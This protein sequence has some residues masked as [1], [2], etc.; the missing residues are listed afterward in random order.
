MSI[1]T[2]F[3]ESITTN[4]T[5]FHL[6]L[7]WAALDRHF[8]VS[9]AFTDNKAGQ[10][11]REL[12]DSGAA[13]SRQWMASVWWGADCI[14]RQDT[15]AWTVFHELIL[16]I[17]PLKNLICKRACLLTEYLFEVRGKRVFVSFLYCHVSSTWH[18]LWQRMGISQIFPGWSKG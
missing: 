12:E 6:F 2:T 18:N 10:T 4:E 9:D 14:P 5:L 1:L 13:N 11:P 3:H 7:A 16:P 15:W 17:L 8:C